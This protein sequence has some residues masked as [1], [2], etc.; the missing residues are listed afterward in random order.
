ML[1][2]STAFGRL[3][4]AFLLF[5][6]VMMGIPVARGQAPTVVTGTPS[7]FTSTSVTIKGSVNNNGS[8][9]T[10]YWEWGTTTAYGTTLFPG[11]LGSG[12]NQLFITSVVTG[13]SPGTTY[14]YQ[15]VAS[16]AFGQAFGGDQAFTTPSLEEQV[17]TYSIYNGKVTITGYTGHGGVV[18]IPETIAGLR[19][20]MI[21]NFAFGGLTNLTAVNIP[22]SVTTIGAQ[23]FGNCRHLASVE[24]A[25]GIA[26]I[27]MEAFYYCIGLTNITI[28]ASVT[29]VD[30]YAFA[31]CTALR[32]AAVGSLNIGGYQFYGCSSLASVVISNGVTTIGSQAFANCTS[33]TSVAIPDSVTAINDGM[34]GWVLGEGAFSGCTSL[35]NVTIGQS[36]TNIGDNAFVGCTKLAAVTIPPSVVRIGLYAFVGCTSLTSI[37]IPA[38]VTSIVEDNSFAP[39]GSFPFAYCTSLTAITVDPLNPVYSS[40]DGALFNK[41]Q[42]TLLSYPGGKTGSYT[43]PGTV[44]NMASHAFRGSAGLTSVTTP[45]S[46]TTLGDGVFYDCTNLAS[47][48]MGNNLTNIGTEEFS[49]CTALTS[50]AVG[51]FNPSFSSIDGVM[52]DKS[53]T[54]LLQFPPGKAGACTVPGKVRNIGFGFNSCTKVTSVTVGNEVTNMGTLAY[55]SSLT[56]VIVGAGVSSVA[57]AAFLDCTALKSVYFLGNEPS[58]G[59]NAFALDTNA[60]VYFLPGTTGW[61]STFGGL[62]AVL[63]NPQALTGDGG[64]GVRQNRFGFNISGTPDIPLVIEGSDDVSGRSWVE[65]QSCTLTNGLIYFRDAQWTNYPSRFYRIR[66]P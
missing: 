45:D 6:P 47:V 9:T 23:A 25:Q 37:R 14:H 53:Q 35:T 59:P 21:G 31:Y 39:Y 16:N 28:P 30:D 26:N 1:A 2:V 54:T 10:Y 43:V 27:G 34:N 18:S 19:V 22:A 58:V 63:W 11:S 33:L 4:G 55:C 65:L 57:E 8:P 52:F 29:W 32:S 66:S 5:L 60:I 20:V 3:R 46:I 38:G 64:F 50:I 36:V 13:L 15:L 17:F 56:N 61:G 12:P 48:V 40:L 62:P 44:T 42:T 41:N 51:P 24:L 49:G 7:E